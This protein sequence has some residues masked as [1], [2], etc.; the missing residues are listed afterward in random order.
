MRYPYA[1]LLAT[2]VLTT[3]FAADAPATITFNFDSDVAGR[4]P[5]G[6][7][8][9]RTGNGAQGKWIVKSEKDAPSTSNVLVQ[10]D[11]DTTDYRFPIA[12]IGPQLKDLHLS[13]KCKAISG[14]VDQGCGLVFRLKDADNYYVARANALEDNVRL[15][16]VIKGS[17]VQFAGWNGAV[18]SGMWHTLA[19]DA[20]GD[21]FRVNFDGKQVIDA[22]D[23]TFQTA[24]KFGLWTKADSVIEFDDL[25][26]IPK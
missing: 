24:G 18:K 4:A 25:S 20:Q 3:A 2:S 7:V 1:F 11:A 16:H 13:V 14:K 15:Y 21:A 5:K 10:I 22:R 9:G 8:F 23:T 17:R 12:F 19:V 6:F 26:A